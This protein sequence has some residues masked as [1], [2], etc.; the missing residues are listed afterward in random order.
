M[1]ETV[2]ANVVQ[3][4]LETWDLHDTRAA[5]RFEWVVGET[6]A[7]GVSTN[8]AG[9]VV[10]G[11]TRET[12]RAGFDT[13]DAG[14]EGV[15]FANRARDDLLEIHA[16]VLEKVFR[17]IAAMEAHRLV[18]VGTVIVIPI[19]ERTGGFRGE[20]QG[21]HAEHAADVDLAGA[22]K[23]RV[24]HHAH[25]GARDDPEILFKRSPALYRADLHVRGFHPL[26]DDR[27][28]LGH[29]QQ[30]R[31]GNPGGRD[32]PFNRLQF[33][34]RRFVVI[35]H[36]VDTAEHFGKIE[37]FHG[38]AAA[39]EQFFAVTHGV[40]CRGARA[41]RADAQVAQAFDNAANRC[42]PREVL[43]EFGR[44]GSF[45]VQRGEGIR[46]AVLFE[47]VAGRHFAAEAVAAV[48]DAHLAGGV[49]GGLNQ[50]GKV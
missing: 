15:L 17:Q 12:H 49:G 20:L 22:G 42:K 33:L 1:L 14:A 40:E 11:E 32:V 36:T 6:A 7:A 46:K 23:Q 50:Y 44:I 19:E 34:R 39:F 5:E 8:R 48:R 29:F 47:V 16:H 37:R 27:T 13:A 26:V 31:L 38:N 4:F 30:C 28:E 43:R 35:L 2:F 41:D 25:Q 24:A 21:V 10:R 9:R 3:K 45:G 18:G